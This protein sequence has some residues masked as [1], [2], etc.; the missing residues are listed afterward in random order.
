MSGWKNHR[1]GGGGGREGPRLDLLIVDDEEKILETLTE[2]FKDRYEVV[3]AGGPD[4]ALE[5][6]A[7]RRPQ[8]VLCDQ[9][10][11]G[12]TGIEMLREIREIEPGTIRM[13]ITGYS[14]IEVVIEA[15]NDQILHRYVT[16][17]WENEDLVSI[18][19][20]MATKY[21]EENGLA[22]GDERILF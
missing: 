10:M 7:K 1:Q 16:K 6:F 4:E 12:K 2:L 17:P 18:V 3:T 15:V 14:D 8:M 20:Q 5:I 13:L 21:L 11:P 22:G 9:R 19:D